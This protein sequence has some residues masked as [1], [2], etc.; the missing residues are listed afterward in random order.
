MAIC[1][2]FSSMVNSSGARRHLKF[3]PRC[4]IQPPGVTPSVLRSTVHRATRGNG[5]TTEPVRP[6]TMQ[7]ACE[8]EGFSHEFGTSALIDPERALRISRAIPH[9]KDDEETIEKEA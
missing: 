2:V 4:A 8:G 5:S 9:R 6:Q 7:H 3:L 1:P